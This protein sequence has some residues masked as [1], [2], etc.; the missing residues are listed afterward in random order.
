MTSRREKPPIFSSLECFVESQQGSG[1]QDDGELR[2][3]ACRN[4]QWSKTENEA[5]DRIQ[6]RRPPPRAAADDQLVLQ[7]RGFGHDRAYS[8][9]AHEFGNGGQDVDGEYKQVNH[10]PGR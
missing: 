6:V 7:Q 4:E 5:I 2:K 3:P 1:L 9:G 10:R 8:A